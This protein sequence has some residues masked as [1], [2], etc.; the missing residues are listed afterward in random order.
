MRVNAFTA[1][2]AAVLAVCALAQQPPPIS[3]GV[4]AHALKNGNVVYTYTITNNSSSYVGAVSIGYNYDA[5]ISEIRTLPVGWTHDGGLP[6][7]SST[8]PTGWRASVTS[9]HEAPTG[10]ILWEAPSGGG[11]PPHSSSNQF[12]ITVP[13]ADS[14]YTTSHWTC[15]MS[16]GPDAFY[17]GLLPGVPPVPTGLMATAATPRQINLGWT[18]TTGA[19]SYN[20]WRSTTSGGPYTQIAKGVTTTNYSD[21]GLAPSTAYYYVLQAVNNGGGTSDNSNEASAR[22][23]AK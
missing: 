23:S 12:S 7:G 8:S 3:V 5:H 9:E 17:T 21:T 22:T 18:A 13:R 15:V 14:T 4:S 1:L 2:L 16:N 20:I 6:Q 11:I 10:E 19:A